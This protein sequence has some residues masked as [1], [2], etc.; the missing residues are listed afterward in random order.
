MPEGQ[1][2]VQLSLLFG[3]P[4]FVRT[5]SRSHA[6]KLRMHGV[7]ILARGKS[8]RLLGLNT[9]QQPTQHISCCG[10][11]RAHAPDFQRSGRCCSASPVQGVSGHCYICQRNI[12]HERSLSFRGCHP[13]RLPFNRRLVRCNT[14]VKRSFQCFRSTQLG[15]MSPSILRSERPI[16]IRQRSHLWVFSLQA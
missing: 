12:L 5:A 4:E 1:S 15:D 6:T 7:L 14:S 11:L 3:K 16:L 8:Y 13:E 9:T 2:R 10:H